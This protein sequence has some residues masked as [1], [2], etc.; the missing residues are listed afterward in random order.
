MNLPGLSSSGMRRLVA[1]GTGN[2]TRY[3][4]LVGPCSAGTSN[5]PSLMS[6]ATFVPLGSIAMK[7]ILPLATGL[8][9]SVTLPSILPRGGAGGA[10]EQAV[11]IPRAAKIKRRRVKATDKWGGVGN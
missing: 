9:L 2:S 11:I 8:P 5:E 4:P 3:L 1:E 6:A 10:D 7:R